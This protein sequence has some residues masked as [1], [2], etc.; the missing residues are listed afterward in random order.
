MKLYPAEPGIR[1]QRAE[2]LKLTQDT[3]GALRLWT[4]LA[5]PSNAR[6]LAAKI[7]CQLDQG[8]T[9]QVEP[10]FEPAVSQEFIHWYRALIAAGSDDLV[11]R[12][13]THLDRLGR[14]LPTAG[15]I[16]DQALAEAGDEAVV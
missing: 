15:K 9:I 12:I 3:H 8:D 1:L 14:L 7:L 4:Q 6:H 2:A 5:A 10:S 11:L 16:L 13:N